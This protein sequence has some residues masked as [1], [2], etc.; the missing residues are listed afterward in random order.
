MANLF[1]R[2]FLEHPRDAR[3]GY[4]AHAAAA[5]RYGWR[6]LKA[7]LCAFTHAFVPG[8]HKTSASDCVKEMAAELNGRVQTT[9]EERMRRSGT[10]D[11]VI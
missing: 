8:L 9:R 5:S 3:E 4:F 6:L 1:D 2:L 10:Y 7:S 11:P